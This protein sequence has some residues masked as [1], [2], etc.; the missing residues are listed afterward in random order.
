MDNERDNGFAA[1]IVTG[2]LVGAGLALLFAPKAGTELRGDL[3]DSLGSLRDAVAR[4]YRAL[5]DMA[6]VELENFEER[7][8][9]A[10]AVDRVERPRGARRRAATAAAAALSGA[11]LRAGRCR[12]RLHIGTFEHLAAPAVGDRAWK[13]HAMIPPFC[14]LTTI[15]AA[16]ASLAAA[17]TPP[18]AP[19]QPTRRSRVR[20]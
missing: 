10:A 6:G 20:W 8:D 19:T 7:V 18:P 14:A 2:A 1:G 13:G 16:V 3:N 5:A 9:R 11:T 4:R 15:G 17:S 12:R